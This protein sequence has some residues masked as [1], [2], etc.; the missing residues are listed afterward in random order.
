MPRASR[1][2]TITD[3][4][5]WLDRKRV[6]IEEGRW[7]DP[8]AGK[9]T[10]G[11]WADRWLASARPGL[12]ATTDALYA[13]LIR[14][15][16]KPKFGTV[17]VADLRPI[18]VAEWVAE[19]R[20]DGLS[21]SRIRHAYI[22]LSQM[23]AAPVDNDMRSSSPC[24]GVKLPRITQAEP[25]ILTPEQV[26]RLIG[27]LRGKHRVL[28]MLLAY[29]GLRL[30]EAFA[31]RRSAVDLASQRIHVVA[32]VTE[33]S[34]KQV[35]D[36]PKSHQT[37]EITIPATVVTALQRLIAKL[38]EE[39]D[40]LVFTG[41]RLSRPLRYGW[42]REYIFDPAAERAGLPEITPKDLRA[43]HATWV[44]DRLGVMAAAKRLGHSN[45]SVTTRH[46]ARAVQAREDEAARTL[47]A[48]RDQAL[49]ARERHDD[50]DDGAAGVL[51]PV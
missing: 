38:P 1:S 6:E 12:K 16:I 35:F 46:Y 36:L 22:V 25:T 8:D 14:S 34:G 4:G 40:P 26:E 21:A 44:A 13:G 41:D 45:A 31:L 20:S 9:T 27:Q 2:A 23:M 51:V 47:D 15:R 30:G 3:A 11:E 49:K 24:R 37:R 17:A 43:T 19:M 39:G 7:L 28:V 29:A 48:M 32:S 10:V 33:I 18:M 5:L 50:G 42:W